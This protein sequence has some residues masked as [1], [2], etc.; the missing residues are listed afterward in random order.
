MVGSTLLLLLEDVN[1]L[2]ALHMVGLERFILIWVLALTLS[3]GVSVMNKIKLKVG[4]DFHGVITKEP[5][6][7]S[8]LMQDLIDSGNEVHIMTGSRR[9]T[10]DMELVDLPVKIP[11]THF[12]SIADTLIEKQVDMDLQD[13]DNP[14]CLN[15]E[16]WD[17]QKGDYAQEVGINLMIDDEPSYA[18]YFKTPFMLFRGDRNNSLFP[19]PKKKENKDG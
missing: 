14:W 17:R 2:S 5:V 16:L 6:V 7:M 19:E 18:D 3:T 12:F 1:I 10:F 13:P 8:V 4:F 15:K 11:F 9:S